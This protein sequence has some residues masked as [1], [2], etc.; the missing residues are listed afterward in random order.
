MSISSFIKSLSSY[1]GRNT[2]NPWH[3]YDELSD[4]GHEAPQ[5]RR[6]QLRHYLNLRLAKV[7]YVV[8][9]EAAGYQ[10]GHFTGIAITCERMLLGLHKTIGAQSIIGVPGKRTSRPD[11]PSL[12][13]TAQRRGGMNEPTDTYIWGAIVENGLDPQSVLLWNIYPFHPHKEGNLFSNRTPTNSELAAGLV[14]TQ[15]LLALFCKNLHIA[16]I[17]RKSAETLNTA[18]IA[19]TAMRH[20]ANGGAGQFRRDFGEW[21]RSLPARS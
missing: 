9:A 16:A 12:T 3:D 21:L 10:G 20:P 14:Y 6:A 19:A 4:I 7:K 15:N 1:K 17:G 8:I 13:S 2:F 11:S 5:I 18:G